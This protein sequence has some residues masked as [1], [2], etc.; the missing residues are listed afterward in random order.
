[1]AEYTEEIRYRGNFLESGHVEVC[2]VT[3][4]LRDGVEISHQNHRYV[5]TPGDDYSDQ[6][7]IIQGICKTL[8]TPEVVLKNE[9]QKEE[10]LMKLKRPK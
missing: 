3:H 9:K 8:H 2:Q 7:E 1:M 10:V 6:P 4:I 5:I